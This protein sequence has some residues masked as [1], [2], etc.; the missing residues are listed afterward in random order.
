MALPDRAHVQVQQARERQVDV[1]HLI[2]RGGRVINSQ[3][4]EIALPN[5]TGLIQRLDEP[6]RPDLKQSNRGPGTGNRIA[7]PVIN[8]T[9][10]RLKGFHA[11]RE[12]VTPQW[13][14]KGHAEIP[15]FR[16]VC[17]W[18]RACRKPS[19]IGFAD[20]M[21]A[22]LRCT[23]LSRQTALFSATMPAFIRSMIHK[24]L[25]DPIW[26]RINP[27]TPT[28]EAI[29]QR[30]YEVAER[31]KADGLALILGEEGPESR[32]LIFRR[33]QLGVDFLARALQRRGFPV[34]SLHGGM[35]QS[36]RNRV[37]TGFRSG[38]IRLVVATNVA[39][40][41]SFT[42]ESNNQEIGR[43]HV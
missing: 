43:A 38:Q 16:W 13:R 19:D 25:R 23:P 12:A 3:F 26:V 41:L 32:M 18:A 9:K 27:E 22:I 39:T 24:Y 40:G 36:E 8:L 1:G 2:E 21:E 33:T 7:V 11:P 10:T 4:P 29:Q 34:A 31:D 14:F 30:Y 5:V 37:M 17:S 28:V 6:G 35:S 15:F 20:D 42:A